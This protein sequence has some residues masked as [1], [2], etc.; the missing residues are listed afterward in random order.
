[1]ELKE[2]L[3]RYLP[4]Y[5]EK[6]EEW[7][8]DNEELISEIQRM[9]FSEIMTVCLHLSFITNYIPEALQ[10]YT[11]KVCKKQRENCINALSYNFGGKVGETCCCSELLEGC[12]ETVF[13]SEQP[14]IEDL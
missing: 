4:N 11:D 2:F 12:Y 7:I 13:A 14:K 5:E 8:I 6:R 10:N 3:E 9:H 1:M